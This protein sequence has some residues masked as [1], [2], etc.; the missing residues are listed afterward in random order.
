MLLTLGDLIKCVFDYSCF[1]FCTYIYDNE[2]II[3]G[4][5]SNKRE[6]IVGPFKSLLIGGLF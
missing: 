4:I 6:I 2:W 5:V 3:I 1:I